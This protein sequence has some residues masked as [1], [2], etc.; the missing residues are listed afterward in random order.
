MNTIN[1]ILFKIERNS[2]RS[3]LRSLKIENPLMDLYA[4]T[5]VDTS[6]RTAVN[7]LS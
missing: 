1:K 4:N 7:K 5:D 2:L 6:D 3:I